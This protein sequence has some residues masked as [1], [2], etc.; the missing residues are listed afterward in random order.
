M[1]PPFLLVFLPPPELLPVDFL[2]PLDFFA[3]R[4]LL[5]L[6]LVPPER[7]LVD[8]PTLRLLLPPDLAP[9]LLPLAF[10]ALID[11]LPPVFLPRPLLFLRPR[12]GLFEPPDLELPKLNDLEEAFWPPPEDLPP[13]NPVARFAAPAA[14]DTARFASWTFCGLVAAFPASAP[15]TPPTTAPTG[16]ATLPTTAPAAAPACAFEIGGMFWFDEEVDPLS[17]DC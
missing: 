8:L 10:F 13:P 9:P 2:P 14:C 16:P 12:A 5:L 11:L 7:R 1:P 4:D 3:P 15:I 17:D 6:V